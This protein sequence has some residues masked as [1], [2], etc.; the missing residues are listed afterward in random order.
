MK[1]FI[2]IAGILL[3]LFAV[4]YAFAAATYTPITDVSR[5]TDIQ[6][7]YETSATQKF[8]LGTR[9]VVDERTFRYSK[10]GGNLVRNLGGQNYSQWP[11]NAAVLA[12]SAIGAT[13]VTVAETTCAVNYYQDG[14]IVFFTS[15]MQWRRIVSNTVSNGTSCVLTLDGALEAAVTKD[16]TFATGYPSIYADVRQAVSPAGYNTVVCI[17]LVTVASGSYFW[18]QTW[19]PCYAVADGTVPG[20]A[21]DKRDLYWAQSGNVEPYGDANAGVGGQ[22]AGYVIPRTASG[23]GDQFFMLQLSP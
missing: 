14:W 5:I 1:R 16:T 18:G 19:G 9:I 3:V 10:A 2:S 8:P 4:S 23:S 13:T 12:T 17:P 6:G 11:I 22:V 15:P 7:I 20:S 21:I